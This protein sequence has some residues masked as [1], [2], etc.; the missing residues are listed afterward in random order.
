MTNSSHIVMTNYSQMMGL[1]LT[2][3]SHI[4]MTNYN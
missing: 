4:G 1:Y 3:Y 2:K